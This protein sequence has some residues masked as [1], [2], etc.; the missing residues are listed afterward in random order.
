MKARWLTVCAPYHVTKLDQTNFCKPNSNHFRVM[1]KLEKTETKYKTEKKMRA[2]PTY[3][4]YLGRAN[5]FPTTG[6]IW[7]E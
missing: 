5:A 4:L 3:P 6:E 1:K 2:R 7:I